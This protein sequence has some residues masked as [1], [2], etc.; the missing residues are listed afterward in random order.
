MLTAARD[1]FLPMDRLGLHTDGVY[2]PLA[3]VLNIL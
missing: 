1:H 3:H 2:A